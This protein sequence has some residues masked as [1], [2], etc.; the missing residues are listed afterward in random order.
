[1]KI[2]IEEQNR[3]LHHSIDQGVKLWELLEDRH[4]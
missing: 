4:R 3:I 2:G 1:M